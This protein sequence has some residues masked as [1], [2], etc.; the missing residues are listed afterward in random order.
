[1]PWLRDVMHDVIDTDIF[2]TVHAN[3]LCAIS[4]RDTSGSTHLRL[5]ELQD[6]NDTNAALWSITS[7]YYKNL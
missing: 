5:L 7:E 6:F 2:L 4:S 1:M 3:F